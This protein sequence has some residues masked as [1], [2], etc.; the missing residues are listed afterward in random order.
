MQNGPN[1]SSLMSEG[2]VVRISAGP[3]AFYTDHE[4]PIPDWLEG[5][6]HTVN[7]YADDTILN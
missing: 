3:S 4:R 2:S 6:C 5:A 1:Q 7:I